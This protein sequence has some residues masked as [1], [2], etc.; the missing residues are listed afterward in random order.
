M[1]KKKKKLKQMFGDNT[2]SNSKQKNHMQLMVS[3][4][5]DA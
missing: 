1:E 5:S 2:S 4:N 3:S